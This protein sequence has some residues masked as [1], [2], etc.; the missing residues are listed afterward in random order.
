MID[1]AKTLDI[2]KAEG[3]AL[4]LKDPTFI[5]PRGRLIL[6]ASPKEILPVVSRVRFW[7]EELTPWM[8]FK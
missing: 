6:P 8:V 4:E 2:V 3:K 1:F 7:P 5:D